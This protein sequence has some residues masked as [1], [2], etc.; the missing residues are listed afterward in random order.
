MG[1]PMVSTP[2]AKTTSLQDDQDSKS[3]GTSVKSAV[4][5][6]TESENSSPTSENPPEGTELTELV[7]GQRLEKSYMTLKHSTVQANLAARWLQDSEMPN[8]DGLVLG[9]I[10]VTE[11][12]CQLQAQKR[13]PDV[14][15]VTDE[16][17]EQHGYPTCFPV[18]FPLVVEVALPDD[19]AEMLF[20]KAQEYLAAQTE[21]VWLLYP[22]S[23]LVIG[24]TDEGWQIFSGEDVV[25]TQKVLGGVAIAIKDLFP[26]NSG[27]VSWGTMSHPPIK[28]HSREPSHANSPK[29]RATNPSPQSAQSPAAGHSPLPC[30][31]PGTGASNPVP[32]P[33]S[34]PPTA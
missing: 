5:V 25:R 1:E 12:L 4:S 8:E 17:I 16:L 11:A 7:D 9:G 19:P 23:R 6:E 30:A 24:V 21:D 15:Y 3:G 33:L 20:G 32:P 18:S 29:F 28:I 2:M 27:K 10:V 14:A 26:W 34:Q 31:G 22:E 13:R